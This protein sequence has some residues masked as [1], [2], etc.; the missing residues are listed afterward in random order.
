M[1]E[2]F[3]LVVFYTLILLFFIDCVDS[4]IIGAVV[5]ARAFPSL[6]L[7]QWLHFVFSLAVVLGPILYTY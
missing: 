6:V 7:D 4:V 2:I 5:V 3:N 1:P